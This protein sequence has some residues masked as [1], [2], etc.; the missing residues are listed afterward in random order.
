MRKNRKA[1]MPR[2]WLSG[3]RLLNGLVRPGIGELATW[4]PQVV[5]EA[6]LGLFRRADGAILLA[7]P[8][9]D[10]DEDAKDLTPVAV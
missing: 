5:P 4:G 2:F 8:N 9:K 10:A 7:I 1:K 3:P 6:T